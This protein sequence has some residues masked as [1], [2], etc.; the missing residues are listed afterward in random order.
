MNCG[1][2]ILQWRLRTKNSS[3]VK[4][5]YL[6]LVCTV[7]VSPFLNWLRQVKGVH[8]YFNLPDDIVFREAIKVIDWHYQSLSSHLLEWNLEDRGRSRYTW[9][10][11]ISKRHFL[12]NCRL[13][14]GVRSEIHSN[15]G[16]DFALELEKIASLNNMQPQQNRPDFDK[17]KH[18][19]L[20][21]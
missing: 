11:V 14:V 2:N 16:W 18:F 15:T 21:S 5:S 19:E 4:D 9:L 7:Q 10:R 13:A 3:V 8:G 20:F 6:F 17:E 1:K 12:T